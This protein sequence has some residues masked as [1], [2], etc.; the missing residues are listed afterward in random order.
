MNLK[1]RIYLNYIVLYLN[2]ICIISYSGIILV[3]LFT[4]AD[5]VARKDVG[6][7]GESCQPQDR[8]NDEWKGSGRSVRCNAAANIHRVITH[9]IKALCFI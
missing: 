2:R 4:D 5:A 1:V 7:Q 9:I 8:S 6:F 3:Y